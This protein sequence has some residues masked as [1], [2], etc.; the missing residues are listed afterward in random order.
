[1]KKFITSAAAF[2]LLALGSGYAATAQA[3]QQPAAAAATAPAGPH[4]I[5]LIDMA[6]VFQKYE[7]FTALRDSLKSEIDASEAKAK[8][9]A[10]QIQQMEQELKKMQES[11]L[12]PTSPEFQAKEKAFTEAAAE[13]QTF[14]KQ[15]Q[16]EFLQR[17]AEMYKTIYL[18]AT[19]M[20]KKYAEY[21]K[22]TMVLRF[23]R[24]DVDASENP[25][26]ILQRMNRQ[27][28]YHQPQ[29]DIT[30]QIISYLNRQYQQSAARP[31]AGT[32]R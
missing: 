28:V 24:D 3:Q 30:D 8:Q 16:R 27:V 32:N 23:N 4:K 20:V 22:Y 2:A 21:Q 6:Q 10:A 11:G 9:M 29:D 18:E 13:M 5:A 12:K 1:M 25:Q 15:A 17:E 14:R 31:A 26:E 7:K 19:T